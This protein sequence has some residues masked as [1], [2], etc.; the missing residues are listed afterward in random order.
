MIYPSGKDICQ[1]KQGQ[2]FPVS[3]E[4]CATIGITMSSLANFCG[5]EKAITYHLSFQNQ[6]SLKLRSSSILI[7]ILSTWPLRMQAF[8]GLELQEIRY[9]YALPREK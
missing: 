5:L 2:V 8:W 3:I 9:S 7:S 6:N 4:H 1:G